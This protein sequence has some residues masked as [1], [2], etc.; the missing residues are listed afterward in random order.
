MGLHIVAVE[1]AKST[2]AF[3]GVHHEEDFTIP[4]VLNNNWAGAVI[5][6]HRKARA[7]EFIQAREGNGGDF[8]NNLIVG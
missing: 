4:I 2:V 3:R 8:G 5:A 1:I 7:G 6:T